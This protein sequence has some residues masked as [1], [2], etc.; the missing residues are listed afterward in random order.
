[1]LRVIPTTLI[2]LVLVTGTCLAGVNTVYI[3]D[4][5]GSLP[6][7][8]VLTN[9]LLAGATHT[10]E[11]T[12]D[13]TGGA[14]Y[15]WLGTN[16]FQMYSP[17]GADWGY[18]QASRADYIWDLPLLYTP[19]INCLALES[20]VEHYNKTGGSGTFVVTPSVGTIEECF[21]AS[22]IDD[23]YTSQPAGGNVTGTDTVGFYHGATGI[24]VGYVGGTSG[25]ALTVEF[26]SSISDGGRHICFGRTSQIQAWEWAAP[27]Y[28]LNDGS[29][30]PT[31]DN[32]LGQDA[33]RCW[34]LAGVN[35]VYISDIDGSIPNHDL[36]STQ[37]QAGV[38]HTLEITFDATPSAGFN[39]LGTNAF[40]MYSPDGADWGYLH[41]TRGQYILDLPLKYTPSIGCMALESFVEHFNKTGGTGEFIVTPS[42]GTIEECF[43]GFTID[44][45]YTSQP[46][47]GNVSGTDTVG[48]YHGAA[49]I[50]VGFVGG[51]SGVAL[52]VE[53]T[54]SALDAGKHICFD[55]TFDIHAWEWAAPVYP[56]GSDFPTWDNGLGDDGPRCWVVTGG[57]SDC[58]VG[59]V[60]DINV[61]GED[62][63]TIGDVSLV[64]DHLFINQP[65]LV[66]YPE[67]DIN[68][69]GG[70]NPVPADITIGDVSMLIDY[71][72]ISNPQIALPNC[73]PTE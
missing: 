24:G 21:T 65:A 37:L 47:G 29:D 62:E 1:M 70:A 56:S 67:A 58:C 4:V 6:N 16:A 7:H 34:T 32:G 64:I 20:F 14:G 5:E 17:D 63:P 42:V 30:F 28:P 35:S 44:D 66:C 10:I 59:R 26:T 57:G 69:S 19:A 72:F 68:Q 48:F 31:Y 9:K 23:P 49:G 36:T 51:T 55:T 61:S 39:W 27:S 25:V 52:T 41:A 18:L 8:N 12:F 45:P 40:E 71:L 11:I 22:T 3:S 2:V 38:P 33:P 13:A 53:F 43:T 15:T 54:S 50:G 73:I 60:G 46:A